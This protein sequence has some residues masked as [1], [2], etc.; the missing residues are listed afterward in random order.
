MSKPISVSVFWGIFFKF[1]LCFVKYIIILGLFSD[2]V[3]YSCIAIS[4]W[5]VVSVCRL[6]FDILCCLYPCNV[7]VIIGS[8]QQQV[9]EV[10][11]ARF[12][13]QGEMISANHERTPLRIILFTGGD[14]LF[15][16][17]EWLELLVIFNM[18][19]SEYWSPAVE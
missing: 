7:A 6:L 4:L 12:I 19:L 17:L 13:A 3:Y 18:F 2:L 10:H 1:T 15:S 16:V 11:F 14:Y 8:E 9:V 5:F